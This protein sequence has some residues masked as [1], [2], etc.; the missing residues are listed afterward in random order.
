[1]GVGIVGTV[2]YRCLETGLTI[3]G[4]Q[5]RIDS[6]SIEIASNQSEIDAMRK[7]LEV[8]SQSVVINESNFGHVYDGPILGQANR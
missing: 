8:D 6:N 7:S 4:N 3:H 5:N 2:G 1:M